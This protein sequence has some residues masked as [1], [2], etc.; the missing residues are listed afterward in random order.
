MSESCKKFYFSKKRVF[1]CHLLH[2]IKA[3]TFGDWYSFNYD[4][5]PIVHRDSICVQEYRTNDSFSNLFLLVNSWV[6][7]LTEALHIYGL[8]LLLLHLIRIAMIALILVV[9]RLVVLQIDFVDIH[10][11]ILDGGTDL[12]GHVDGEVRL[13]KW[14]QRS[15]HLM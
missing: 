7:V 15:L 13:I 6:N 2:F 1:R 14:H 8:L 5:I 3:T 9:T 10:I 11:L 12:L 4:A